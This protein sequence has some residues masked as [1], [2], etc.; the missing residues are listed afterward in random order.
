MRGEPRACAGAL[1]LVVRHLEAAKENRYEQ[2]AAKPL[3][4]HGLACWRSRLVPQGTDSAAEEGVRL[5]PLDSHTDSDALGV[6]WDCAVTNTP[7]RRADTT[8]N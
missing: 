5:E 4:E 3:S 6:P 8:L 1:H 7:L 2:Q